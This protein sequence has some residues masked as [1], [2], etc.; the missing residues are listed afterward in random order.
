MNKK[1][2]LNKNTSVKKRLMF[3]RKYLSIPYGAFMLIFTVVPIF[4]LLFYAFSKRGSFGNELTFDF[5]MQ[6]FISFFSGTNLK[7]ISRSLWI[8]L[9]TTAICLLIG[10]P[11]A[12]ILANK[13]Y[14]TSKTL[15]LLFVL[16]MWI[17]F[18]LRTLATKAMFDFIGISLGMGTVIFGMVY[19]F[20]P[21]MILPIYTTIQKIDKSLIEAA[22]D[23]GASNNQTFS[24]VILPLSLPGILS[25]ITM[26]FTPT[27]T[28]FVVSDMLS[29][30]K[31]SLIGNA[32]N[33]SI[34]QLDYNTASA[35]SMIILVLVGVTMLVVNRYDKD[36]TS[37]G[38]GL[39]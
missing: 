38:G 32:I 4:I 17:N 1:S 22:N 21:F 29:N 16:P 20:L 14:N 23:L 9:L 27:I 7:L 31:I 2:L 37:A 15:I 8:G 6:N 10:Y 35:M 28:T 18:L 24:K 33:N 5:T 26:V 25:G 34:G 3:N 19:N 13:K 36:K 11:T 30:N 39:W 12:Y